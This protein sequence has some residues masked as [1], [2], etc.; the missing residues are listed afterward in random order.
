[1]NC[2]VEFVVKIITSSHENLC[3]VFGK[4]IPRCLLSSSKSSN[5]N[6]KFMFKKM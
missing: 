6:K 5:N 3:R 2:T 4:K 1:M